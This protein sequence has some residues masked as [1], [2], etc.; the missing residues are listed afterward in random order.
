MSAAP[1]HPAD[2]PAPRP[3]PMDATP[4]EVRAALAAVSAA[5]AERFDTEWRHALD[6]ARD[7]LDLTEL[8]TVLHRWRVFAASAQDNPARHRRMMERLARVE[9]GE[10]PPEGIPWG[11]AT[12]GL[13]DRLG[14]GA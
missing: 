5:D 4:A 14:R 11:V 1:A 6:T 8:D 3:H 10:T 9:A 2:E 7:R 12:A 13:A